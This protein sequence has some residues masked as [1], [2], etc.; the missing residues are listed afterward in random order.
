MWVK[1][2][3]RWEDSSKCL[4]FSTGR[5]EVGVR[6]DSVTGA[7]TMNWPVLTVCRVWSGDCGGVWIYT[8]YCLR[9]HVWMLSWTGVAHNSDIGS[10]LLLPH[11]VCT[12]QIWVYVYL[13]FH[14]WTAVDLQSHDLSQ[15]ICSYITC[16]MCH[17]TINSMQGLQGKCLWCWTSTIW[18]PFN[19]KQR[20][21]LQ[22]I[23]HVKQRLR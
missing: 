16:L 22:L 11:L 4:Q 13:L 6:C 5:W 18:Q 12:E 2:G 3:W 17:I 10:W 23:I 20:T 1:S 7:Q 9:G 19:F 14:H 8:L 21:L 15:R